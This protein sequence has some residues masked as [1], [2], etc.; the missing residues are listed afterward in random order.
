M[1]FTDLKYYK[2][3]LGQDAFVKCKKDG[4]ECVVPMKLDNADYKEIKK[5]LDAGQITIAASD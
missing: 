4:H 2:N 5:Q 3:L 1:E